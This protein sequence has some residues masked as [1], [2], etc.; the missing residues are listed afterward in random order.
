MTRRQGDP[1]GRRVFRRRAQLLAEAGRIATTL[2]RVLRGVRSPAASEAADLAARIAREE[3]AA[4]QRAG[5]RIEGRRRYKRGS[6]TGNPVRDQRPVNDLFVDESGVAHV[7]TS[8]GQGGWFALGGVAMTPE[9]VDDYIAAADALKME[10]FG[11]TDITLHEPHM[12]RAAGHF[13]FGGRVARQRAFAVAV[14]ELVVACS[15]T[16]FAVGIRKRPFSD[17]VSGAGTDLYLPPGVYSSSIHLLLERYV[18]FL[19]SEPFEPIGRVTWEAQGP[20]EDAEHQR[21]FVDALLGGTRR[22]SESGFRRFLRPGVAF[23]PKSGSHPIELSDML[24]RDVFEWIRD[25][26]GSEPPR[27]AIFGEKFYQRGDLMR[28]KFGLKV[29]PDADLR[30]QIEA[31]R[32]RFRTGH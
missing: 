7:S 4:L 3:R 20:R 2:I 21:D 9:A 12:R 10:F 6:G 32:E 14:D 30:D 29:F 28:G 25:D 22:I 24:A 23:V 31:H 17:E 13:S 11:R 19:A 18:D 15:F 8:P 16:A 27:W 5:G 26:C 1:E